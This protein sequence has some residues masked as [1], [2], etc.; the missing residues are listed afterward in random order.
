MVIIVIS[1]SYQY[2]V[3]QLFISLLNMYI[4]IS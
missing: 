4:H 1:Y 3:L 2:Y